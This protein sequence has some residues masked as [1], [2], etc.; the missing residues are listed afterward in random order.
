MAET[1]KE[2][3]SLP[4]DVAQKLVTSIEALHERVDR[5]PSDHASMAVLKQI[6][7]EHGA[8]L[9]QFMKPENALH[10]DISWYNPE[11]EHDHPRPALRRPCYFLGSQ[12]EHAMLNWEEI[13]YLNAFEQSVELPEKRWKASILRDIGGGS[14]LF[15]SMPFKGFSDLWGLSNAMDP[16][17]SGLRLVLRTLLDVGRRPQSTDTMREEMDLLRAQLNEL[18]EAIAARQDGP[19]IS[20]ATT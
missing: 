4:V 13:A 6:L 20:V 10:P 17:N 14:C 9:R 15:I 18:R 2:N 11:G 8:A 12:L 3:V 19:T 5:D 16:D 1:P 7:E